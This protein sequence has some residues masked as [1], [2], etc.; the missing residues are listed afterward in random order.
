L[1]KQ[2]PAALLVVTQADPEILYAVVNGNVWASFDGAH[3]WA[4]R[5]AAIFQSGIDTLTTDAGYPSRIWAAGRG[6]LFRSDDGGVGW[7]EFGKPLPEANTEIHSIVASDEAIVLA[8]DRGIY[9]STDSA[10]KW[11][12]ITDSVP[13]HLETGPLVR[14]PVD[15][16]TLY[17]GF[18]L[19]PYRELW[20]RSANQRS[21]MAQVSITSLVAGAVSLIVVVA[22]GGLALLHFRRYYR[23]RDEFELA[24]GA[25]RDRQ[26]HGERAP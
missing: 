14:D 19:L 6:R 16:A 5:G 7:H 24:A 10:E 23:P 25:G 22:G 4:S 11:T 8:T 13:A 1:P 20:Q 21:A 17:A 9:R 12:L 2:P 18:S 26:F 3:S 15:P